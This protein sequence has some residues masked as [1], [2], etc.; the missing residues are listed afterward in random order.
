MNLSERFRMNNGST[1]GFRASV[2]L[3]DG[4]IFEGVIESEVSYG[5]YLLIGGDSNRLSMFPWSMI[6]RVV[7]TN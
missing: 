1:E 5:L 6:T 4:T 2:V 7:Y 3:N